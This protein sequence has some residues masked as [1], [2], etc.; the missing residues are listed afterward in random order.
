MS[1]CLFCRIVRRD[2][3]AEIM[4]E[5]HELV[6]FKDIHPQAP[7]HFLVAPKTHIAKL[8]DLTDTTAQVVAHATVMANRL[9][10]QAGIV[11]Q[12][13]RLVVNCGAQAGQSVEHLHVHVLGGRPMGWPPG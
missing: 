7:I 2:M 12:G 8:S 5:D 9:A 4:A 10:T 11:E 6:A 1:E 13:Y 3:P